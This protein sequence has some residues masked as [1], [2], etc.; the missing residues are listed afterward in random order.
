MKVHATREA[1]QQVHT[2]YM[3]NQFGPIAKCRLEI[4][5]VSVCYMHC[6]KPSL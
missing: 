2:I 5:I 6:S 1:H 3:I 4:A